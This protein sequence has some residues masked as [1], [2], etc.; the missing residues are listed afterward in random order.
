MYTSFQIFIACSPFLKQSSHILA[1]IICGIQVI[2]V[3]D[4][5]KILFSH[6][7][8]M[9][10]FNAKK[11]F[12]CNTVFS[13]YPC[14][15][16]WVRHLKQ[17]NRTEFINISECHPRGVQRTDQVHPSEKFNGPISY[18]QC[19]KLSS[20]YHFNEPYFKYSYFP[21][22]VSLNMPPGFGHNSQICE[23]KSVVKW[24][25]HSTY[26]K[27]KGLVCLHDFQHFK[28]KIIVIYKMNHID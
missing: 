14:S 7:K 6:C 17:S 3:D 25:Y 27:C 28:R 16:S 20:L 2:H 4:L 8:C 22:S 9:F 18:T 24:T 15:P 10:C 23:K 1:L 5:S 21:A 19:S 13:F 26:T 11:H 12:S